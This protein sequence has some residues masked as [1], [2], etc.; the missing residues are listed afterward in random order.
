MLVIYVMCL[1]LV[2][3][4][5]KTIHITNTQQNISMYDSFDWSHNKIA[6]AVNQSESLFYYCDWLIGY[7]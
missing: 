6:M 1:K 5:F 4:N 2:R 3:R 7:H